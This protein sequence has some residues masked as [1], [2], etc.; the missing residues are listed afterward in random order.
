VDGVDIARAEGLM[1]SLVDSTGA[2]PAATDVSR[3][4]RLPGFRNHKYGGGHLVIAFRF[5]DAETRSLGEFPS[6]SD[7]PTPRKASGAVR[8]M[9][10]AA[11]RL[12]QSEK[13]WAYAKRALRRGDP[14]SVV[15]RA[16]EEHRRGDKSNPQYYARHTVEKAARA[17]MNDLPILHRRS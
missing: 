5:N 3:V 6:T 2:D 7:T 15:I 14:V 4:L 17:I 8:E 12:S 16:I 11:G 1:R 9:Q 10:V 13:D